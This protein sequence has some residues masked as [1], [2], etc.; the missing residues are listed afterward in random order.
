MTLNT[1]SAETLWSEKLKNQLTLPVSFSCC[2]NLCLLRPKCMCYHLF[3]CNLVSIYQ[4][5]SN[6]DERNH[7]DLV[8]HEQSGLYSLNN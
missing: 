2:H 4:K 8:W 7:E 3:Y 5:D 6:K 1:Q